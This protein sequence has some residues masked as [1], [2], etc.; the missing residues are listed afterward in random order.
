MLPLSELQRTCEATGQGRVPTSTQG[1][2]VYWRWMTLCV[3]RSDQNSFTERVRDSLSWSEV[4][5]TRKQ[6]KEFWTFKL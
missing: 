5:V 1:H 6:F 2:L 4:N 3:A